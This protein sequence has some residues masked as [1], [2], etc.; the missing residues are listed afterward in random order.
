MVGC[1]FVVVVVVVREDVETKKSKLYGENFERFF[2]G[3]ISN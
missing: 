1:Y 3:G 2:V